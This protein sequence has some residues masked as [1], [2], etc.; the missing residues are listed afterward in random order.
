MKKTY[1][2]KANSYQD[3][4][5]KVKRLQDMRSPFPFPVGTKFSWIDK[6]ISRGRIKSGVDENFE[7]I[8]VVDLQDGE[9][10]KL[11]ATDFENAANHGRIKIFHSETDSKRIKRI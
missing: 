9:E 11:S 5:R 3:A 4:L 6:G 7:T 2:V 8:T 1:I 10:I